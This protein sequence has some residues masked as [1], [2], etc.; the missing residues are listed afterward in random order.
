MEA[1]N[2][3]TLP[4]PQEED[5][6]LLIRDEEPRQLLISADTRESAAAAYLD[7]WKRRIFRIRG[8][9]IFTL[10]AASKVPAPPTTTGKS[11]CWMVIRSLSLT[12]ATTPLD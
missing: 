7:N 1:G 5:A 3:M 12:E 9:P 4:L 11:A 6:T 10:F 8:G 2:E